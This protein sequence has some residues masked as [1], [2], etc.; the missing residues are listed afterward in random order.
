M[1]GEH[2]AKTIARGAGH[3]SGKTIL[4]TYVRK[5][6]INRGNTC[7]MGRKKRER[8]DHFIWRG[9]AA[10]RLSRRRSPYRSGQILC[11]PADTRQINCDLTQAAE[12]KHRAWRFGYD[13][14]DGWCLAVLTIGHCRSFGA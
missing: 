13:G 14:Q 5:H 10:V 8:P 3:I 11:A 4:I 7:G 9:I 1:N 6:R 12:V 2:A